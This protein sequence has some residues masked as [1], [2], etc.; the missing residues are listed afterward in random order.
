MRII[1]HCIQPVMPDAA[2]LLRE[3]L[4]MEHVSGDEDLS[5]GGGRGAGQLV[6][7]R[8]KED[9][10][11]ILFRQLMLPEAT[12]VDEMPKINSEV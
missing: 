3:L 2:I 12:S 6:K 5:I 4:G 9:R 10:L 8:P 7:K 1:S 11:H